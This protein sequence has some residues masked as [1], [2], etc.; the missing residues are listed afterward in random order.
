MEEGGE[1][2]PLNTFE[3]MPFESLLSQYNSSN[4]VAPSL[5]LGQA[6]LMTSNMRYGA[7]QVT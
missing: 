6:F 4:Q 5:A 7:G 1:G 3:K 2:T